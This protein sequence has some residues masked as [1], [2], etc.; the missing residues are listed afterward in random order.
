MHISKQLLY[1]C[2]VGNS[3]WHLQLSSLRLP[4]KQKK[5][6]DKLCDKLLADGT[7]SQAHHGFKVVQCALRHVPNRAKAGGAVQ[8]NPVD[9]TLFLLSMV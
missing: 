8:Q 2:H 7:G 9:H 3:F 6:R 4:V 1:I 5:D